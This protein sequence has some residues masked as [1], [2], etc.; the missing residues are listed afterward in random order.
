VITSVP[1][2]PPAASISGFGLNAQVT[3]LG[4][5]AGV[6][7]NEYCSPEIPVPAPIANGMLKEVPSVIEL[8]DGNVIAG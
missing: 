4:K 5:V 1:L 3:P 7:A 6:H 2:A 8:V